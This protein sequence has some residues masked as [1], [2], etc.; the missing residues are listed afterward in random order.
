M[1]R[2][3]WK[4]LKDLDPAAVDPHP[5]DEFL[6]LFNQA[7]LTLLQAFQSLRIDGQRYATLFNVAKNGTESITTPD[8][9]QTL[10]MQY[11]RFLIELLEKFEKFA[12]DLRNSYSNFCKPKDLSETEQTETPLPKWKRKRKV[13]TKEELGHQ[14]DGVYAVLRALGFMAWKSPLFEW[15]MTNY[16]RDSIRALAVAS[17]SDSDSDDEP[18]D[19]ENDDD[20]HEPDDNK[21]GEESRSD[22][23][24]YP[25]AHMSFDFKKPDKEMIAREWVYWLR[26]VTAPWYYAAMMHAKTLS[27]NAPRLSFR[28]LT[29]P[30]S[31]TKMKPWK[32]VI[33]TMY[34]D[35]E[36]QNDLIEKVIAN[37][38]NT[39]HNMIS[40]SNFPFKGVAHCEAVLACSHYL[41]N[42]KESVDEVC[43]LS[44]FPRTY[45]DSLTVGGIRRCVE[46]AR[47]GVSAH[48]TL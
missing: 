21:N 20:D 2:D 13:F 16:L 6:P 33:K 30:P 34:P 27:R 22:P 28:L 47:E 43:P 35:P 44:F 3:H 23:S 42:S 9:G 48:R 40:D 46:R 12:R 24:D 18:D 31:S 19:D 15:Y 45:T 1:P 29:Y 38:G 4:I 26:L 37:H 5:I 36:V 17:D 7:R 41:A 10:L 25:E 14:I 8:D 32:E 39:T 11:H